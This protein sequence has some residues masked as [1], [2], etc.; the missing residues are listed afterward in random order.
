MTLLDCDLLQ[1]GFMAIPL[2][3]ARELSDDVLEALRLRALHGCELGFT[4]GYCAMMG[5]LGR[6]RHGDSDR[7]ADGPITGT[8]TR[9][10]PLLP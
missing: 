2:P 1:E 10:G 3:D 4:Q 5:N 7:E 6:L 9:V 8:A